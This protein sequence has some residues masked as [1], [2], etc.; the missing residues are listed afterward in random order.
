MGNSATAEMVGCR[1]GIGP[2]HSPHNSIVSPLHASPGQI[3]LARRASDRRER[4]GRTATPGARREERRHLVVVRRVVEVFLDDG[5]EDIVLNRFRHRV[6]V[7]F[8]P[9]ELR[10]DCLA[11]AGLDDELNKSHVVEGYIL[12]GSSASMYVSMRCRMS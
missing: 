7:A 8:E 6:L 1:K 2:I 9:A 4:T 10:R 3:C 5:A 12:R 11:D